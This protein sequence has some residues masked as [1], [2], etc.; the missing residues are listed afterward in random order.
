MP[1]RRLSRDPVAIVRFLWR[2]IYLAA[3]LRARPLE[4][5]LA[6]V[7]RP[8]R[9]GLPAR[10]ADDP[11]AAARLASA[12][13]R[14]ATLPFSSRCL[15]RSLFLFALLHPSR[16]DLRLIVGLRKT[17]AGGV[18]GHAWVTLDGQP[19]CPGDELAPAAFVTLLTLPDR[20]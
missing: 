9:L 11:R 20:P 17:P 15:V 18:E 12:V 6:R 4:R 16:P 7:S 5:V 19:L 3:L 1:A 13:F 2:G 14:R 8:D 10:Y